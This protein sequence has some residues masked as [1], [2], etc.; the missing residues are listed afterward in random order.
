M[1]TLGRAYIEIVADGGNFKKSLRESIASDSES[2]MGALGRE[3]GQAYTGGYKATLLGSDADRVGDDL[4]A[5]T[6]KRL[7]VAGESGGRDF[8]SGVGRGIA[9]GGRDVDTEVDSIGSRVATKTRTIGDDAGKSLAQR[10]SLGLEGIDKNVGDK[11][12]SVSNVLMGFAGTA[13][14]WSSIIV[15]ASYGVTILAEAVLSLLPI[16][17]EAGQS[18]VQLSGIA[19]GIPAALGPAALALLA[20]KLALS[21]FGAAMTAVD[22]TAFNKAT[23][24]M[25]DQSKALAGTLRDLMPQ[26]RSIQQA[27]QDA[28]SAQVIGNVSNFASIIVGPLRAGFATLGADLGRA[29]DQVGAFI[30]SAQGIQMLQGW[31]DSADI[32][33]QSLTRGL[34]PLLAGFANLSIATKPIFDSL[35]VD[36]G[37]VE[38]AF[39]N[40]LTK[41]AASGQAFTWLQNAVDGFKNL[42][43]IVLNIGKILYEFWQASGVSAKDLLGTI[44][45]LT[46]NF[47]KF[48]MTAQGQNAMTAFFT[49]IGAVGQALVPIIEAVGGVFL[50]LVQPASDLVVALGPGLTAI[51]K[52]LG[53]ALAALGPALVPLAGALSD[54]LISLAPVIPQIADA[55]AQLIIALTPLIPM[56]VPIIAALGV[57]LANALK[58]AAPVVA[59]LLANMAPLFFLLATNTPVIWALIGAFVALK[60]ALAAKE[61]IDTANKFADLGRQ[62]GVLGSKCS[63]AVCDGASSSITK[64][65]DAADKAAPQFDKLA[66]SAGKAGDAAGKAAGPLAQTLGPT[67]GNLA[68]SLLPALGGV[69]GT[70]GSA[71]L[72]LG[73]PVLAVVAAIALLVVGIIL[74]IK[75]WDQV[76]AF[77]ERLPGYFMDAVGAIV[78][79]AGVIGGA[80]VTAFQA[81]VGFFASLPGQIGAFLST[82]GGALAGFFTALPGQIVGFLTGV[83]A[84]FI[85]FVT[86]LPGMIL[87][88]LSAAWSAIWGFLQQ[89][90]S[91]ILSGLL[92]ALEGVAYALGAGIAAIVGIFI[93][94]PIQLVGILAQWIPQ[95]IGWF[96]GLPGQIIGV[97]APLVGAVVGF[98]ASMWAGTVAAVSAGV[99]AVVSFFVAL[100]GWIMGA[101]AGLA[102]ALWGWWTSLLAG[103]SGIIVGWINT[104]I[105]FFAAL[106]GQ[107]MGAIAALAGALLNFFTGLWLGTVNIVT[108]WFTAV[109][110]FFAAL[111]GWI[112]GAIAALPGLLLNFFT[113]LWQGTVNIVVAWFNAV[114]NFFANLPGQLMGAINGLAAALL[115][116]FIGLWQGTVNIVVAWFTAVINFFAALPG[117]LL[118]AIVA[119][120]GLLWNFFWGMELALGQLLINWFN[121]VV[122]FFAALP[123]RLMQAVSALAGMVHNFFWNIYE[124]TL[125]I[126]GGLVNSVVGFFGGLPGKVLD[127]LGGLVGAL[128]D[129]FKKGYNAIAGV[130][131]WIIKGFNDVIEKFPGGSKIQVP[132]LNRLATGG[133]VP[134]VGNRDNQ[135]TL[136]TPGEG[137]LT[138]DTVR[139]LGGRSAIDALN[140]NRAGRII[141]GPDGI[142]RLGIGGI[143]G[144]VAGLIG[145]GLSKA[146]GIEEAAV[147]FVTAPVDWLEDKIAHSWLGGASGEMAEKLR[148][149]PV[150]ILNAAVNAIKGLFDKAKDMFDALGNPIKKIG[151]FVS[152]LFGGGGGQP[153][154]GGA[155]GDWIAQGI[156]KTGVPATWAGP[157]NTLIMRESGGNPRSI[158]NWDINAQHGDPSRGLMQTIGSTFAA[159]RDPSLVNDI[160][161]PVANIVAG[162]RYILAQYG[163]IFN[164][165]QAVGATP[166]GYDVGGI[167]RSPQI[168]ALH[169]N[170]VVIPLSRPSRALALADQ[171]GLTSMMQRRRAGPAG[172]G[173]TINA[174]ITVTAPHSDPELVAWKVTNQ[175]ARLAR[176]GIG[177]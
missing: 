109:I 21:G 132:T 39:G 78:G 102:G 31:F 42:A 45:L 117:Q 99:S 23:Q 137:V 28:F 13:L 89:L 148:A 133:I 41:I 15:G 118:N 57:D 33:M 9:A 172:D 152:N 80:L 46:G 16:L 154:A 100:P 110:N 44:A 146:K 17:L 175:I 4:G 72:A 170:E 84:A 125:G 97:L 147:K 160:Y 10:F 126:A 95:I 139:R 65:G 37:N 91:L 18:I 69:L 116:F 3:G 50:Q 171:S 29:A 22:D 156:A 24:N 1:T 63:S 56:L 59:V 155:L 161:D 35:A 119:L 52:A 40:W 145:S 92:A 2:E 74:L 7:V 113:G 163:S 121:D 11:L 12:D 54:A 8:S 169:A 122:N 153:T 177:G 108:A 124:D 105:S 47:S 30:T 174:P 112:M 62:I 131:D 96:A 93:L 5:R 141:I 71:L 162:I 143:V 164:V 150:G 58:V 103:S 129:P 38:V 76:V 104:V 14:R 114:I 166:R 26:F 36:V 138:V 151:G 27:A 32:G 75:Y 19:L 83:G 66:G 140:R 43:T 48:L 51:I 135:L 53:I 123:G 85:S 70:V 88:L 34:T 107:I 73:W 176:S 115:N 87:G 101:I 111:P 144:G 79:F 136:L 60:T 67:I 68:K 165:Q 158:N 49:A 90:P 106:P 86:S 98:F 128:A 134:G 20:V 142:Q 149:V 82:V 130:L 94:L 157:L 173:V 77:L 127:A 159:Y 6:S 168:A 55:F 64:A 167:I 61:F 25:G 120:P 81:V